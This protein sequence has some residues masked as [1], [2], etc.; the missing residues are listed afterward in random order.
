MAPTH[1]KP[2]EF[3]A[4]IH[5]TRQAVNWMIRTG[6]IPA[7]RIGGCWYIPASYVLPLLPPDHPDRREAD[8]QP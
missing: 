8:R 3:A 1:Y 6:E 7:E 2:S 5:Y 4:L